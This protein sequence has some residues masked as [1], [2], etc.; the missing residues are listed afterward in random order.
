[1]LAL[2]RLRKNGSILPKT[3]SNLNSHTTC[4][5]TH[6]WAIIFIVSSIRSLDLVSWVV[7]PGW[8]AFKN[9]VWVDIW[10]HV[11]LFTLD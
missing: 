5:H 3:N 6:I 2:Y 10:P 11:I 7:M 1:M 4:F 8:S 9:F